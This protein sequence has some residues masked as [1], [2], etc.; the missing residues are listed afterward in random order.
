MNP[1]LKSFI[2][3]KFKQPGAAFDLGAGDYNDV[4]ALESLGWRAKGVDIKDGIDLNNIYIDRE[5]PF[6][7]IYSNYVLHK[8][9]NQSNFIKTISEN[10]K[11]NGF[12]F[13]LTIIDNISEEEQLRNISEPLRQNNLSL[14]SHK[15]SR[16]FDDAPGHKHWHTIL[17]LIGQKSLKR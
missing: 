5:K 14:T 15:T 1:F 9:Q 2:E 16:I 12:F 11:D 7:L 8:I 17:E 4:K 13:I 6:D 10:L 3:K